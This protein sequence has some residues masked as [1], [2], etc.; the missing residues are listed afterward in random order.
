L[1][2]ILGPSGSGKTTLLRIVAGFENPDSG[3]VVLKGQDITYATPASR[4]IGMVFQNYALFPHMTVAENMGFSLK[5]RGVPKADIRVQVQRASETL[6]LGP[7][8]ARH[9]RQL[10]GGQRQRVAMGRSIVRNPKVFLF[11]EPLSNLD[12]KLRVQMRTEL[13]ELHQ[14]IGG[15]SIYGGTGSYVGTILGALIL[16]VLNSMLTF[17]NVGQAVQQIVY[18]TIVLF[19][20]W[21]Y[22]QLTGVHR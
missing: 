1:L 21:G 5:M 13:K 10:S 14:R 6:G 22:A 11:D 9:P 18:G 20:A 7:Y 8:L 2:T 19:L 16:S 12:A 4:N 3:A 17:L 15:T